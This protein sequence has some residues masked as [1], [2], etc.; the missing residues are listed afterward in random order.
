M[1]QIRSSRSEVT[2]VN[3]HKLTYK[4]KDINNITDTKKIITRFKK[5]Y[6]ITLQIGIYYTKTQINMVL[7]LYLDNCR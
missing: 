2:T 7:R 3:T 4:Q 5:K 1:H 6:T